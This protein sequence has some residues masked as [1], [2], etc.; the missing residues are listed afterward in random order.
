V[1][2][3]GLTRAVALTSVVT[4]IALVLFALAQVAI[5]YWGE[6]NRGR[7]REEDERARERDQL[8]QLNLAEATLHAEWFRIWTVAKQWRS[9]NLIER[10]ANGE[11]NPSDLLPRDW[12]NVTQVI[13]RLGVLPSRL[14]SYG[15][16]R[17]N[18]AVA[19]AGR[20]IHNAREFLMGRPSPGPMREAYD[21]HMLPALIEQEEQLKRAAEEAAN[22]LQDAVE[23]SPQAKTLHTVQWNDTLRSETARR[24]KAAMKQRFGSRD[25]SKPVIADEVLQDI[26]PADEDVGRR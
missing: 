17:C 1:T 24:L 5:M 6:R 10:A 25:G 7:E 16:V 2:E 21:H 3:N 14:A 8:E 18:D 26:Q 11:L 15:F 23:H 22:V 9:A 20:F 13:G 19:L 4:S 12:S